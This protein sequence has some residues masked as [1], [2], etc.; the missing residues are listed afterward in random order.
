MTVLFNA[1]GQSGVDQNPFFNGQQ[2]T[3]THTASGG[4]I[5]VLAGLS[6][7]AAN[8][9]L[10][11]F[12]LATVTL[13]NLT[14]TVTYNGVQMTSIGV[15]Q[16][17]A[18][19]ATVNAWTELFALMGAEPGPANVQANVWGGVD[20]ARTLRCETVSYSGVASL[21]TPVIANGTGTAMA[22]AATVPQG[23][24]LAGVWG[25][26]AG[27]YIPSGSSVAQR[28][29]SNDTIGLLM[30]DLPGNGSSQTLTANQ[31]NSNPWGGI[32]VPLQRADTVFSADPF[33][34]QVP[35]IAPKFNR[36]PRTG[37]LRRQVFAVPTK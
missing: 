35:Y 4:D 3:E 33:V 27:M 12:V 25:T 5:C 14:R 26:H 32:V 7:S 22:L 15:V 17:G 1:I 23:G 10:G 31:Q 2:V 37:G 18:S 11:P 21:G 9:A 19:G 29:V 34:A 20:S 13:A 28:Y 36:N 24:L 16:W 8:L 6:Y 30:G